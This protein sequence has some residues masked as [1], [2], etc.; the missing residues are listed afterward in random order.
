M[1][2]GQTVQH[3]RDHVEGQRGIDGGAAFFRSTR[4]GA[5]VP[6][7]HELHGEVMLTFDKSDIE[8]LA[9]VSLAELKCDAGLIE[10]ARNV[11]RVPRDDGVEHLDDASPFGPVD[12]AHKGRGIDLPH[13][14]R[15]PGS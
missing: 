13:A 2:V 8:H 14:P 7:T 6:A 1:R 10:K 15:A 9:D 11:V 12:A 3:F 4:D 5:Q